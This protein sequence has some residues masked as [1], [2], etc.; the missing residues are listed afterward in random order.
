MEPIEQVSI[1][2]DFTIDEEAK[3]NFAEVARWTK[4]NAITGFAS[5]GVS[6]FSTVMAFVKLS[7]YDMGS[8]SAVAGGFISVL[9]GAAISLLLNIVLLQAAVNIKK[10]VEQNDQVL[11]GIGLS[12]LATYF[13]VVGILIIIV[14]VIFVLAFLFT[15]LVSAGTGF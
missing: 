12:R 3:T 9:I 5:L 8:G 15:V 10:G 11:F 1:F 14:L 2:D 6:V 7:N 13:R 4:L